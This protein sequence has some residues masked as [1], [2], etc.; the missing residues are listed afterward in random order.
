MKVNKLLGTMGIA[1]LM[2]TSC[3][4]NDGSEHSEEFQK[5][6]NDINPDFADL[7]DTAD[8]LREPVSIDDFESE[9]IPSN[10]EVTYDLDVEMEEE[11]NF[12]LDTRATIENTSDDAW[13]E[14]VFYVIPNAFTEENKPDEVGGANELDMQSV[15][16]DG[17]NVP[18]SLEN[19]TLA[20]ELEEPLEKGEKLEADIAYTF[21]LPEDGFRF[22]QCLQHIAMAGIKKII[23]RLENRII[24]IS[25]ISP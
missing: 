22:T 4:T 1:V 18:Y 14:L 24:Q 7:D 21:S 6:E 20:L 9:T 23:T 11:G 13:K 2:L 17:E 10:T 25:A 19:D 3:S 8:T 15:Q 16:V 5:S 12:Q